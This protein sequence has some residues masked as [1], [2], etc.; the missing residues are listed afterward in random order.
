MSDPDHALGRVNAKIAAAYD[1]VPYDPPASPGLDPAH[2][3]AVAARYGFARDARDI[4]ILDLGCGTGA[5]LERCADLTTGRLVGTDLSKTACE[6]ADARTARFGDRRRVI[7]A[8]VMGLSA[9]DLGAFDLIYHVGV[10]YVTPPEVQRHLL[11]LIADA[12]KP[13]G[14]AVIS[15]YA[16]TI[17]L[18][19]AGL[20]ATLR[21]SADPVAPP[22]EQIHKA[23]A[24]V[25]AIAATLTRASGDQRLM[26]AVL[27]QVHNSPDVIFF[28]EMLNESFAA[29]STA[30]LEAALAPQGVHFLNWMQPAPFEA[31]ASPRERAAAADAYT[32]AGGGY[33]YGVFAKDA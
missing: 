11:T 7:C 5:Q 19:M 1:H 12:L 22:Q 13:G 23:R 9:A 14:V 30:A 3:F 28:H 31:T 21:A 10:L 20:H 26:S 29:L 2:I 18:L 32:L 8:D 4:D 17:P 16:G 33:F 27:Q 6:R 24:Q 25:Q 15:Y